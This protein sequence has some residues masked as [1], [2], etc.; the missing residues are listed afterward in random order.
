MSKLT[1]V[2]DADFENQVIRSPLPALVDLWAEWCGPCKML[3]PII[4]EIASEYTGRLRV[5]KLNVDDNPNTPSQF[6]ILGIP[7]LL[8]FKEGQLVES[9]TGYMHKDRLL[10]KIGP[11]L[12]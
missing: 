2:N 5:F 8:L 3:T 10:A 1:I 9:I 4:E 7:T 6:G 12:I 11:H